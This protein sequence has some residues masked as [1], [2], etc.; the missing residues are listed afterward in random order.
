MTKGPY[1]EIR[2]EGMYAPPGYAHGML[3]GKILYVAGQVA[4]DAS[5]TLVAPGDVAA[6]ATLV[7]ENLGRILAAAGAA[8]EHVVKVT[9]YLADSADGREAGAAR[10][11]FF[12]E[13]R[14]PHT[15]LVVGL[16]DG[17]RIEVEAVAVLP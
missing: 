5:G 7:Y 4:R 12:G 2:P 17:V 16:S 10:M 11:A 14:P 9:T 15:G 8:P 1:R 3:A 6:Q 13:H